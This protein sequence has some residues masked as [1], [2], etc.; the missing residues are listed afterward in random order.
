MASAE[1]TLGQVL[2]E[3]L[4]E[5]YCLVGNL[6]QFT[7]AFEEFAVPEQLRDVDGLL[8][9]L[10]ENQGVCSWGVDAQGRVFQCVQTRRD[11]RKRVK[12]LTQ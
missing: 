3:P 2:P 9:F 11:I 8:M 1:R 4:T 7:S 5:F 6:P 12:P 10:D